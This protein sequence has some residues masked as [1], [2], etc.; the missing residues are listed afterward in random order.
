M[1]PYLQH[2][3]P[4]ETVTEKEFNI[5][6]RS[7][8]Y[9]LLGHW[10]I[11]ESDRLNDVQKDAL[12][13]DY[14]IAL[15]DE[16]YFI[17][18]DEIA[19]FEAIISQLADCIYTHF[20]FRIVSLQGEVK[21]LD[22][23][24]LL[25][26]C[27]LSSIENL[28][29]RP[30]SVR[31]GGQASRAAA[32]GEPAALDTH[33]RLFTQ[34]L[35]SNPDIIQIVD[36]YSG[37]SAYV[38][39]MLLEA[40]QYP[41]EQIKQIE[42]ENR[43]TELIHADDIEGYNRFLM[44]IRDAGD[45]DTVETEM[46]WRAFNGS[47]IWFR[48]RARVFVRDESG[49]PLKFLA[50]S[51]NVTDRKI[52]EEEKHKYQ[53]LREMEKTRITFFNHVSHEFRTPLMLLLAPLQEV[54][55]QGSYS[56]TQQNGLEMAYRNALRLKKLVNNLLD[57]SSIESG[58]LEGVFR[59]TDLAGFT[60]DL[61]SNFRTIIE[62]T[63]LKF[64]VKCQELS[65]PVYINQ[66]MYEKILFNLLS[67][68]FKFTLQGKITVSVKQNKN[69]VKLIVSDTG[70]GMR[71][72]DI[73]RIFE[74]FVRIEGVKARTYEGSGI[75][76]SLVRELVRFHGA[77]IKVE[78]VPDEGTRF[79]VVFL[80][81]KRHLR[82][83]GIF[84]SKADSHG[85]IAAAPYVEELKG[86][87]PGFQSIEDDRA[88]EEDSA[89][90][91]QDRRPL[92]LVADDNLDMRVYLKGLLEHDYEVAM[93]THGKAALAY[94]QDGRLPDLILSD[95]MMPEIDGLALLDAIRVNELT[96]EIPVIL[97]SAMA[98]EMSRIDG[99]R[100]GAD[101]YL[102]KP[103]S[104]RELLARVDAKIQI[105]RERRNA[106]QAVLHMNR[107]LGQRVVEQTGALQRA[108]AA[109]VQKN[110]ELENLN[111]DLTAF[112]FAAGHDLSEPLRNILTFA[113]LLLDR[114]PNSIPPGEKELIDKITSAAERMKLLIEDVLAYSYAQ[115]PPVIVEQ[116][117]LTGVFEQ[118]ASDIHS[119]I[120]ERNA[121]IGYG[122]LPVVYC[123]PQQ[124]SRLFQSLMSNSIKFC[125]PDRVPRITV[126]TSLIEG[127]SI[128][129]PMAFAD[130]K[131]LRISIRDNGI[132]FDP[133][134]NEK[135][136]QAFPRLDTRREYSGMGMGLA[137]CKKI[138]E[139][140]RGFMIT[141]STLG[142][143]ATFCCYFPAEM[144][145]GTL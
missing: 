7:D 3:S 84:E 88:H 123:N 91:L 81:G 21:N 99:L 39:R 60:A 133:Q 57:F 69:H 2:R 59:P 117:D 22:G 70:I 132:G 10:K 25:D 61:A 13:L 134:Y 48:T 104:A 128:R 126:N 30:H 75:G 145:V 141:D 72:D 122:K 34:I 6:I 82:T 64:N 112:A 44:Q 106:R 17:H 124:F 115:H 71:K 19:E 62:R 102:I 92:V 33:R 47:W 43:L 68:A 74:R 40:L 98:G 87:M 56:R 113:S 93:V 96:A 77:S 121:M 54:I 35:E 42:N 46:R 108:N 139:N 53:I 105:A 66:E 107:Q 136:F 140:H 144:V 67:N 137:I 80:K 29:S 100:R 120:L 94:I 8:Q 63:G 142:K 76:L 31:A 50:F 119:L 5:F 36:L 89:A 4:V 37:R 26:A 101:D 38:N 27:S 41:F 12:S 127:S 95:V 55:Q 109:L 49:M 15:D 135:V 73:N 23:Q 11:D 28:I 138:V 116:V 86:W 130:R 97:V 52:S 45:A 129:H 1:E 110:D 32:Y 9:T 103:F 16:N 78:S 20:T 111:A 125:P 118:A 65:E 143:G 79:T 14:V 114:E 24:G 83:R 85:S 131:Y 90:D 51:Q 18:P 58:K